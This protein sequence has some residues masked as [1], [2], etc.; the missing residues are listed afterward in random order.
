VIDD[1]LGGIVA[2]G[3][4]GAAVLYTLG[5]RRLGALGHAP[6]AWRLAV[7]VLGLAT[8]AAAVLSPLDELAAER[9]SAHMAQHLLLT[10]MAAPA[11]LLGNPLP[12]SLWA[13]PLRARRAVARPLTRGALLRRTLHALTSLPVAWALF[14]GTLWLWHVPRLYEAALDHEVVHAAEHLTI[15]WTSLLFWWP[16][17]RPAPRLRPEDH[18]GFAILY[19]VA[20]TAQ[21]IALGAILSVPERVLY[22]RYAKLAAGLGINPLDDQMLAGGLMWMSVHMYLLPIVL[23]LL[24]L[25]RRDE[26]DVVAG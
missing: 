13:L 15:F 17:V 8:V 14:V 19:L 1:L 9:F 26:S 24:R 5:W 23:I 10:M 7:Y 6:S 20:A 25:S 21:N 3:L 22:P 12:V 4:V 16:I 18:P 11:L 2:L